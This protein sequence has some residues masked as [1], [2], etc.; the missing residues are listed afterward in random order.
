MQQT[1]GLNLRKR[2]GGKLVIFKSS[3]SR[4]AN[5]RNLEKTNCNEREVIE[6]AD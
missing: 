3:L 2:Y 4:S 1:F 6:V 5:P